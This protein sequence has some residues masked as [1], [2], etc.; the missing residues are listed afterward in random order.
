MLS[1]RNTWEQAGKKVYGS[2][3]M[4]LFFSHSAS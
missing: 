2:N 4:G 3:I 1:I